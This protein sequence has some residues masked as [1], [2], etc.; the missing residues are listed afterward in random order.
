[1]KGIEKLEATQMTK[2][3]IDL[4]PKEYNFTF[5]SCVK[6]GDFIFTSHHGGFLDE[7]GNK[8]EGIEAQTEQCLKNLAKT[9]EAAGASLNDVVKTTVLLKNADDFAK[10]REVYRRHFKEGY[11]A[12]TAF[13]N[14]DF[15]D[16]A[17]LIQI[18]AVAYK[19]KA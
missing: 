13:V 6:A 2:E 17:C 15:L 14:T 11:P 12:R 18:E 7:K 8:I 16:P 5:S 3:I 1:M 19:P 9:L 10:M 4:N